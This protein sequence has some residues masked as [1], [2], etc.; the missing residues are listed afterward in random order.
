M[1]PT[2]HHDDVVD[3]HILSQIEGDVADALRRAGVPGDSGDLPTWAGAVVDTLPA[4]RRTAE[5]R[6]RSE[7]DP[8]W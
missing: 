7:V 4:Y 5:A 2:P 3:A 6:M 8:W 1:T